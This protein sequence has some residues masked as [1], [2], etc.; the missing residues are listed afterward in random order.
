MKW[1]PSAAKSEVKVYVEK[2]TFTHFR[3]RSKNILCQ[4]VVQDSSTL[5]YKNV[6]K[7]LGFLLEKNFSMDLQIE[8]IRK[9]IEP[10]VGVL[11]KIRNYTSKKVLMTVFHAHIQSHLSHLASIY[12]F[13]SAS[14]MQKLQVLQNRALKIIHRLEPTFHTL[15]LYQKT[16]IN[17]IPVK[18]LGFYQTCMFVWKKMHNET[19]SNIIFDV[20]LSSHNTRGLNKLKPAKVISEIGAAAI[21][22]YGPKVFNNLPQNVINQPTKEC[23]KQHLKRHII[24]EKLNEFI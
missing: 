10:I 20:Q 3:K 12:S 4:D 24:E 6:V 21:T 15:D 18:A 1:S 8:Q 14:S 7:Q 16:V 19:H 9:R 22:H 11:Y 5:Q 2:P 17:I 23:F 13:G